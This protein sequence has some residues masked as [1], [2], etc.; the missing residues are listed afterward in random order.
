MLPPTAHRPR[1]FPRTTERIRAGAPVDLDDLQGRTD[2][3]AA[4]EATNR[5]MKAVTGIVGDL[6][7]A[8]PPDQPFNPY[9]GGGAR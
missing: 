8:I 3:G 6:R 9:A 5:I 2:L 7:G 1:L 4:R